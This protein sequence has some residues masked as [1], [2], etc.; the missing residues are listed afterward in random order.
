MSGGKDR[1][2]AWN[3]SCRAGSVTAGVPNGVTP[4][5]RAVRGRLSGDGWTGPDSQ[6]MG[7]CSS[8]PL[9]SLTPG[10]TV[11]AVV[12]GNSAPCG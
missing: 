11:H 7:E 1:R 6:T 4:V 10:K 9:G 8:M 3:S 12:C 2:F 5:S